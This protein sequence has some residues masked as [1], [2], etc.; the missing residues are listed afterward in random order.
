M[1]TFIQVYV[2]TIKHRLDTM[3]AYILSI[4]RAPMS[5]LQVYVCCM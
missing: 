1:H 2:E 3:T 5:L 4:P